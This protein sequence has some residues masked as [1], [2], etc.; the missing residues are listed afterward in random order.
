ML[1]VSSHPLVMDKI[2]TLR[3]KKTSPNVFKRTMKELTILL[4]YEVT[5]NFPTKEVSVKTPLDIAKAR[6]ISKEITIVGILR[7]GLAMMDGL[8]EIIPSA[9]LAHIGIYR[10]EKT[11]RPVK[12]YL[13][14]PSKLKE[15]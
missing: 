2:K 8:C 12:Y 6:V 5:S 11:L 4:G 15:G 14:L 9:R 10:D 13:K 1:Y 3:D 7:A